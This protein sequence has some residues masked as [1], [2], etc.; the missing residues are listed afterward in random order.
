MFCIGRVAFVLLAKIA[1]QGLNGSS[2]HVT[3][4][5]TQNRGMCHF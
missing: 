1:G 5:I 4:K 2:L 3:K